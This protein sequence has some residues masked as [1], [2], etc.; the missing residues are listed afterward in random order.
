MK[1]ESFTSGTW[2][3]Q[4]QYKSF[5]PTPINREWSWDDPRINV[6]LEKATKSL[7][8]LNAFTLIVPDVDRFIHMRIVK[9]ANT[10]SRIEGTRTEMDEAVLD[11]SAI[12]PERGNDWREVRNYVQAMNVAIDELKNLPLSLRLLRQTHETLMQGARGERKTPPGARHQRQSSRRVAGYQVLRGQSA[13]WGP[14]GAGH[15]ARGNRMAAE[16]DVCVSKVS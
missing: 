13:D 5:Q 1:F 14:G 8:E 7:G 15:T 9:E 4:N 16:P 2:K 12:L 11:E 3:Q 6:L 10:S